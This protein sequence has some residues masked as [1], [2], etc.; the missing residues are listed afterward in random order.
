M[1]AA[2]SRSSPALALPSAEQSLSCPRLTLPRLR[3]NAA[4][5]TSSLERGSKGTDPQ[6]PF[7]LSQLSLKSASLLLGRER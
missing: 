7:R 6:P 2:T 4:R 3:P 1:E 5:W